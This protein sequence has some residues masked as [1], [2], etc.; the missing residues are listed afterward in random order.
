[1]T[2]DVQEDRVTVHYTEWAAVVKFD[3]MLRAVIKPIKLEIVEQEGNNDTNT[4]TWIFS[5][6]LTETQ[7][8]ELQFALET[9]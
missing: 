7:A 9:E 3:A 8:H 1:M 6:S 4:H 5:T 2:I